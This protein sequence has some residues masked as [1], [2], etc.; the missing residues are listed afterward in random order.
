M[1]SRVT[2]AFRAE[3]QKLLELRKVTANEHLQALFECLHNHKFSYWVAQIK[4]EHFLVHKANRGGL[5]L[6]PH[7][8]HRNA[9]RIHKCGADL[10]QLT[11][12]LCM[13]LATTGKTR[14]EHLDKNASLIK[15]AGGLLA[16]IND[17]ERY[18][19]LGCGHTAA[20]CKQAALQGRTSEKSLQRTDSENIDLQNICSNEQ[21]EIM[22]MEGWEWEVVP[23]IID[24]LF[25]SFA[26]IAQKALNT[27]N[28]ISTE[29]G[30][31]ETCMTL[32][33]NADDP[34]MQELDNWQELALENVVS[35]CVPCS[36]YSK[37]LLHFV[38]TFGGGQGIQSLPSWI[39]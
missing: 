25:P 8:C 34:G 26:Q 20:F 29:V 6:S 21:F 24:E 13:E 33:A 4:V 39:L 36:K 31:L 35:L 22:I 37:T 3:F 9:S 15:R 12:A 30:E 17:S 32:A 38:M 18:V 23:A 16:P 28:H 2:P 10:K 27:Q 19:T 5:L 1:A 7:N 14:Q 11:H